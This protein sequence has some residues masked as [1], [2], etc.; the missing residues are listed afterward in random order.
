[1]AGLY[2]LPFLGG[3]GLLLFWPDGADAWVRSAI[4]RP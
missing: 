3:L 2:W 4:W 1:V